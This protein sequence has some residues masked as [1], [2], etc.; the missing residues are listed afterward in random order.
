M[1]AFRQA[2]DFESS[3][4]TQPRRIAS[5]VAI[6][7]AFA[8][9]LG[10]SVPATATVDPSPT[11]T[12]PSPS[13]TVEPVPIVAEALQS[14]EGADASFDNLG[15]YFVYG[16]V[17]GSST[18][19]V[20]VEILETPQYGETGTFT[21]RYTWLGGETLINSTGYRMLGTSGKAVGVAP[22][23]NGNSGDMR[24][25]HEAA[26]GT[27]KPAIGTTRIASVTIVGEEGLGCAV[28]SLALGSPGYCESGIRAPMYLP[29][30]NP[31]IPIS[32]PEEF[33]YVALGDSYQSGEGVGNSID[34]ASAYL[35][36]AYENGLNYPLR[37]G[38]QEN[39][40]TPQVSE[41][42]NGCHRA[43]NNYAKLNANL[44][45]P[46]AP[47]TLIDVTCSGSSI[48]PTGG[49]KPPIVGVVGIG[50]SSDSQVRQAIT[51]LEAAGLDP[52]DVDLVTVGMGGNDAEFGEIIKTCLV[53][54][55]LR[56]LVYAY[57]DSPGEIEFLTGLVASCANYDKLIAKTDPA[58]EALQPKE[59]WAQ[60]QL[61]EAFP[62][63]RILQVNYP[64]ILP[65]GSTAP[66]WCGGFRREDLDFARSKIARIEDAINASIIATGS[67]RLELVD[68]ESALGPNAL[69]PGGDQQA[70]AVALSEANIE[71]ELARLLNL[72]GNGDA[73]AR[74][75]L[76]VLV[77]QY[78]DVRACVGNKLNP[79]DGD[80][81]WD[82]ETS[83]V[84]DAADD[85]MAY[86]GSE[87]MLT[88]IFANV[89]QEPGPEAESDALRFDRTRGLFHPNAAAQSVI[90][91]YLLAAYKGEPPVDCLADPGPGVDDPASTV[92][93][94]PTR[95]NPLIA[96]VGE[97]LEIVASGFSPG[98]LV[99]I[100][101]KSDPVDLGEHVADS[102]GQV[103]LA[104]LVPDT[105]PGVHILQMSGI[106]TGGVQVVNEIK[107]EIPGYPEPGGSYGVY[108]EGFN[109][110]SY[111]D[112][113]IEY[114][115]VTYLGIHFTTI[116]DEEGGIFL[117]LPVPDN[118]GVVTVTAVS[119]LTGKSVERI[120]VIDNPDDLRLAAWGGST[121]APPA[122][123]TSKAG[124]TVKVTFQV[125]DGQGQ[126]VDDPS[127]LSLRSYSIDCQTGA[128]LGGMEPAEH[129]RHSGL[130][131]KGGGWWQASWKTDP[132]Y[133]GTCR[134]FSVVI[135]NG[136]RHDLW[137]QFRL[138]P[139]HESWRLPC[140]WSWMHLA[141]W[142]RTLLPE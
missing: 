54:N 86:L 64:D 110:D 60:E 38:P 70:Y 3:P 137:F 102:S 30:G 122:W 15:G 98:S 14:L 133:T 140:Y 43:L 91:C 135:D 10:T 79:F 109:V 120:L 107:L 66:A 106:G 125:L 49:G 46:G 95:L 65:V 67:S 126:P 81:D 82:L 75:K 141:R 13:P 112:G 99:E 24:F 31:N 16:N 113:V 20:L 87:E 8:L 35:W 77:R 22:P 138:R 57:P 78:L 111:A 68:L 36:S 26:W 136:G 89:I 104:I 21:V 4:T 12:D 139:S 100:T 53:P 44:L 74:T 115:D 119:Q 80:C 27:T 134:T 61:L 58:I 62:N 83:E 5:L 132:G 45:E 55:L 2:P 37:V 96:P 51:R 41:D 69:C 28:N 124:Q 23:T 129:P 117:D 101:L 84:S 130:K 85:L 39:T 29:P 33:V 131:Y 40:Y 114:I 56:R 19:L 105:S 50:V 72:D 94:V 116:P 1:I 52:A 123:N 73:S 142:I 34:S 48:E 93:G 42:G 59:E 63:A 32:E 121:S 103:E 92:D 47:V 25:Y 118:S 11:P 97:E 71:A 17:T 18:H 127:V 9:V 108:L 90:A 76:D 6:G 88:T 7:A 128:D